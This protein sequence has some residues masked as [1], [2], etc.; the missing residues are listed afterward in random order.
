MHPKPA[1]REHSLLNEYRLATERYAWAVRELS[2]TSNPG[3]NTDRLA[4]FVEEERRE[5]ER[6]RRELA[7][8]RAARKK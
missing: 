6:I 1:D 8:F 2:E 5:C 7:R 3:V 4:K